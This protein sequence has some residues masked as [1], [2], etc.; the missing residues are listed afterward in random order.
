[1]MNYEKAVE[2]R[3][4]EH[5]AA[6]C[7]E[8]DYQIDSLK[9]KLMLC[10]PEQLTELQTEIR[11]LQKIKRLPDDVVDREEAANSPS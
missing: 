6:I 1:M 3:Q 7:N 4:S 2:L 5:W 10:V 9:N 8:L 11:T